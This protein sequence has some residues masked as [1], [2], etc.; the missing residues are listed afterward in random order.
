MYKFLVDVTR[1][2]MRLHLPKSEENDEESNL[3]SSQRTASLHSF[4][5]PSAWL[6][7]KQRIARITDDNEHQGHG[8]RW[9]ES[10]VYTGPSFWPM[11]RQ[12]ESN[13]S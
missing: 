7:F 12:N 3:I 5:E 1:R 4:D 2:I 11:A 13:C 9:R 6:G 8:V 10:G